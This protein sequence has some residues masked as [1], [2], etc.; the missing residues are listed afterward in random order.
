MSPRRWLINSAVPA[1]ERKVEDL[2]RPRDKFGCRFIILRSLST[3][4]SDG[5]TTRGF[6]ISFGSCNLTMLK[7]AKTVHFI[8]SLLIH[9][10]KHFCNIPK[11][12]PGTLLPHSLFLW[13]RVFCVTVALSPGSVGKTFVLQK[14]IKAAAAIFKRDF[15]FPS[16]QLG[17]DW[18]EH[19]CLH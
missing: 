18:F 14:P 10:N 3:L 13:W 16:K 11:R 17:A 19:L 6:K 7:K 5:P 2:F 15:L 8:K 4:L 9:F 12:E 1:L